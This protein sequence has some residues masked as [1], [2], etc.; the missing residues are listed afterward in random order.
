M[1]GWLITL[2][3]TTFVAH[4]LMG[5][6]SPAWSTFTT[7]FFLKLLNSCSLYEALKANT[8]WTTVCLCT[9]W[10][11]I[12]HWHLSLPGGPSCGLQQYRFYIWDFITDIE[13][14]AGKANLVCNCGAPTPRTWLWLYVSWPGPWPRH[15]D[16]QYNCHRAAVRG[17]GFRWHWHH[18]TLWHCHRSPPAHHSY[19]MQ[20]F[21]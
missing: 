2:I 13:H 4:K 21:I 3:N 5:I 18:A 14:V 16:F 11:T 19:W 1:V 7:A 9:V 15:S 8:L 6:H 12:S 10:Y 20:A 17:D